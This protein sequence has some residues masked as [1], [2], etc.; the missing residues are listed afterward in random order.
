[1][2]LTQGKFNGKLTRIAVR[3]SAFLGGLEDFEFG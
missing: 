2:V 1:M 3:K